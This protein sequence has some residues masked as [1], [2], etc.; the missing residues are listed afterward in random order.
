MFGHLH[1]HHQ[2]L[3]AALTA[4][5]CSLERGGSSIVGCGLAGQTMINNAATTTFQGKTRGY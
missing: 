5:S 4:S 2:E 3:R 1:A